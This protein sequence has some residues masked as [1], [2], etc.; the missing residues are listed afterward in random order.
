[1]PEDYWRL[2]KNFEESLDDFLVEIEKAHIGLVVEVDEAVAG[3]VQWV[4][5]GVVGCS[6]SGL[7]HLVHA[8]CQSH[9]STTLREHY[10]AEQ[11]DH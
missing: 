2:G 11:R 6:H 7:G 4:G 3:L 9:S 8:G 1:M 5:S 10:S